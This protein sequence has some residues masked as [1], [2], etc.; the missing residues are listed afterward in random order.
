MRRITFAVA[1]LSLALSAESF[2]QS[3]DELLAGRRCDGELTFV[4]GRETN[5]NDPLAAVDARRQQIRQVA[6]EEFELTGPGRFTRDATDRSRPFTYVCRVDLRSGRIDAQYR[7]STDGGFDRPGSAPS[8]SPPPPAPVRSRFGDDGPEGTLWQ[9]AALIGRG[10]RKG[11]DVEGGGRA[12]SARIQLWQYGGGSN[13]RWEVIDLGRNQYAII[14]QATDKVLQVS[15]GDLADGG[16]ISQSRWTGADH[17]RWRFERLSSDFYRIVNV[18]SGKCIDVE[19]A[20]TSN[21]AKIQ[22]WSC[23]GGDNQAWRFEK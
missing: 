7:W 10:S 15:R 16:V 13:Q 12:D 4:I 9:H 5:A 1:G 18:N 14:N 20:A 6:R 22:Q 21:G 8:Q 3:R 11:L 23:S 19:A 17:Q 2:A